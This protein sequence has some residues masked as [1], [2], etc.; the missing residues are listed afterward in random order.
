M[1]ERLI[2][3]SFLIYGE[4]DEIINQAGHREIYENW[5][6]ADK[7]IIEVKGGGHGYHVV[8]WSLD[9]I[10]EWLRRHCVQGSN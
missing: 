3:L 1:P 10:L 4:K 6:S 9:R 5:C 7:T 8:M 2:Y